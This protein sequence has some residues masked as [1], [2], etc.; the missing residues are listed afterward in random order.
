MVELKTRFEIYTSKSLG[1]ERSKSLAKS[2]VSNFW[3]SPRVASP[4]SF[5]RARVHF[6]RPTF[7]IAKIRHYSQSR[8]RRN[9]LTFPPPKSVNILVS[10]RVSSLSFHSSLAIP[11]VQKIAS[12]IYATAP[13]AEVLERLS[14]ERAHQ[15]FQRDRDL[16]G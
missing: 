10:S 14:F 2:V 11:R 15:D 16:R 1:R 4:R 9:L 13:T 5:A 3:Q 6:A 7:A 8:A 12:I